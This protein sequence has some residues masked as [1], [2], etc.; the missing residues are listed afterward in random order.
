MY[1][2]QRALSKEIAGKQRHHEARYEPLAIGAEPL[3]P[4][5][6]TARPWLIPVGLGERSSRPTAS[7]ACVALA[8]DAITVH[9]IHV[10]GDRPVN[11]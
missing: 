7:V 5:I 2:Q 1:L 3:A 8:R 4:G 11:P 9:N 6:L 10:L